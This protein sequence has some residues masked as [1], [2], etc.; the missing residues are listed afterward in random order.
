MY[1]AGLFNYTTFFQLLIIVLESTIYTFNMS[2]TT[3]RLYYTILH[4]V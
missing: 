3:F 1:P 2:Q 4:M